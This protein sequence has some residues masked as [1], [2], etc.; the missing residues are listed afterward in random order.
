MPG[1]AQGLADSVRGGGLAPPMPSTGLA[2]P[3]PDLLSGGAPSPAPL[4][5]PLPPPAMN[6]P[7]NPAGPGALPPSP[8]QYQAITQSDGSVVLHLIAPG[9]VL[10]P[11]VKIIPPPKTPGAG[12]GGP[13]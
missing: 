5:G 8:P 13:K 11:A 4:N 3:S 10:G 9:G 1:A 7:Q 6:G 12:G 2:S